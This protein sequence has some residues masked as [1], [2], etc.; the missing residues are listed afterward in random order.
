MKGKPLFTYNNQTLEYFQRKLNQI[1]IDV[2]LQIVG[3]LGQ[4]END[5]LDK[6]QSSTIL[7][8]SWASSSVP[9]YL[10]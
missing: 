3:Q 10:T 5:D 2:N 7:K 8:N 4:I 9:L 6:A 1:L